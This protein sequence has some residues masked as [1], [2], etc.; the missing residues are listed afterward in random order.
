[1][2]LVG[3]YLRK[4]FQL[5]YL[6]FLCLLMHLERIDVLC[7]THQIIRHFADDVGKI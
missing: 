5:S 3:A 4:Y 2:Y 1:M 6:F 7:Y